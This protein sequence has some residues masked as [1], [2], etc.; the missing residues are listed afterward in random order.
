MSLCDFLGKY[1]PSFRKM[2]D[3]K[4]FN[5]TSSD[6]QNEVISV[7]A[8]LVR[9]E[10]ANAV[11]ETGFFTVIADEAKSSKSEQL[12]V[13]IRYAEKLQ[14][15]ERLICF[16]DCSASR[17]AAGIVE[18]IKKGL[19]SSGLQD[20]PIVAQSYDGAS[21]M[22]GHLT[23]VQQR[24]KE[25]YP[26]AIYVHCMAHKLNLVL[27]ESCTVNRDIKMT[28]NVIDKLYSVFS[29]PSNH[30]RFLAMQKALEMKAK[31]IGQPSDTRWASKWRCVYAVKSH[32]VPITRCL[33]EMVDEGE[34]WSVEASGLYNH[35]TTPGFIACLIILED[36][37]RVVHVVHK[38]L[39][40]KSA[41]LADAA[42]T[43]NSLRAHLRERRG[44]EEGWQ[45]IWS[46][47]KQFGEDV[48][49][50]VATAE[51]EP[52]SRAKRKRSSRP[53]LSLYQYVVG[54]TLG[55]RQ[56]DERNEEID[57]Q[58]EAH[59]IYCHLYLPVLDNMMAELDR[60]F[61][62]E[63]MDLAAACDAVIKCEKKGIEPLLST[64]A[65]LKIVHPQ[66]VT[67]EMDLIKY[68]VQSPINLKDLQKE[69]SKE[70]YP[71]FFPLLQLAL[72]L[73]IGSAT[74]E[75]SFSAMRRIRNWLRSTM[76][77]E[78]FSDLAL[79]HIEGDLTAKLSIEKIV[80]IYASRKK[81]RL[82]LH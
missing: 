71:N 49:M 47:I 16:I 53:P 70:S 8:E 11:R 10:I 69:V 42:S 75:R 54:A 31:E 3:E 33:K 23:G 82:M 66:L 30:H 74:S 80:D 62:G 78:R 27:V 25:D 76:I 58:S 19:E 64:Y 17:D 59:A 67:A 20:V 34:K 4:Y 12:S 45:D 46:Q 9:E 79:L 36:L 72:T 21:V 81:R 40:S 5:C 51:S 22:S 61:S 39:Q 50:P 55:Q 56:R 24:I 44:E 48:G 65:S 52:S 18:G 57:G 13:C 73:P 7:C 6:F 26:F 29:E 35:M 77:Q 41:T 38:K 43:I 68:A 2:H 32:Y 28:L 63:A 60:R 15:K 1:D 37:L 14:V